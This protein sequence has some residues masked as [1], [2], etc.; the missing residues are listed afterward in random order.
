MQLSAKSRRSAV[1]AAVLAAALFAAVPAFA[2]TL[3]HYNYTGHGAEHAQFVEERARAFMQRH[4]DIQIEII[5]NAGTDYWEKLSTMEAGGVPPDILELYPAMAPPFIEARMVKDLGPF[6]ERD[7]EISLDA[8]APITVEG[9][10]WN[11][12]LW[13]LPTSVYQVITFYNV[14]M[15]ERYGHI[16]PSQLGSDWTWER[17]IEVGKDFT[18]DPDGDG[19]PSQWGVRAY[20]DLFRWWIFVHQAGGRLFDRLVDPARATF[21]TEEARVGLQFLVDL[22]YTYGIATTDVNAFYDGRVGVDIFDGPSWFTILPNNAGDR[23]RWDIAELPKGPDNNGTMVFLNGFQIGA[24]SRNP[25]EAWLWLK[26]LVSEESM[27]EYVRI[28]GR[29]PALLS[30]LPEYAG[31]LTHPPA[32]LAAAGDAII[33]PATTSPYFTKVAN[34]IR[35]F[36]NPLTSQA[37]SGAIPVTEA[38]EQMHQFANA[39]LAEA[40]A[41]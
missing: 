19:I 15:F 31:L 12:M 35:S 37:M 38:L 5:S 11:E 25:E 23:F 39:K 2:V 32:N 4:P 7:P 10:I 22:F 13:G 30:L 41:R 29:T 17:L 40:Q 21:T 3:V 14:D 27:R 9:F 6:V 8:Y 36:A 24:G 18:I 16:P 1:A 33:N 34:E 28:T 20:G 26:F